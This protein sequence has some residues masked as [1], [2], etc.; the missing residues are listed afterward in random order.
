MM[1]A[2]VR[3][4]AA[5]TCLATLAAC[6]A[7]PFEV[8]EGFFG[9]AAADEP[10]AA[11]V[12]RDVLVD[13][14][15]AAD[16]AVAGFFAL[17]VT[18]PSSAG[19]GATGSCVVFD[20]SSER[21]EHLSFPALPSA[22]RGSVF[23]LPL[24][25]RAMFALHARYGRLRFEQLITEAE[26]L[27]RFGEPV[28]ARLAA[29]LRWADPAL[30]RDP[31]LKDALGRADG[32]MIQR[33]EALTQNDLGATLGRLRNAGI[34]DLYVGPMSRTFV[35]AVKEA[36]YEID[37]NRLRDALPSWSEVSAFEYDNHAWAMAGADPG[38]EQRAST[39]LSA[40]FASGGWNGSGLVGR[41]EIW[42]RAAQ[43]AAMRGGKP[44]RPDVPGATSFLA[45]DRAGQAVACAVGMGRPFGLGET[46]AGTGIILRPT[47]DAGPTA[48]F[49]VIAGNRNTWQFHLGAT[50]GGG[51]AATTALSQTI[52]N[53]YEGGQSVANAIESPRVHPDPSAGVLYVEEAAPSNAQAAL[54]G[55]GLTVKTTPA[56][57]HASV[58][59]CIDG[60]SKYIADCDLAGDPR[61]GG[62]V[63]FER[64]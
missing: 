10:R 16:A 36:G 14:G 30:L 46:A 11:L 7:E 50:A 29:D 38:S 26:R 12:M 40:V 62:L 49:A 47:G 53:H 13:G 3:A 21:F 34:G 25:P 43:R 55:L 17:S 5:I 28:S 39:M 1:R 19:M 57:G 35:S 60:L 37:P 23:A 45:V 64:E 58:F 51:G 4:T 56:L 15:R 54:S 6:G 63:L 8:Q 24:A 22:D 42:A 59:R 32:G 31:A 44:T 27:A 18:L 41:A 61:G 20:P 48:A 33:G 52:L 2:L 9:G